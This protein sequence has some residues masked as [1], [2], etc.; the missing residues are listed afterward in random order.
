M[1]CVPPH[2]Q[3]Q[4]RFANPAGIVWE[5]VTVSAARSLIIET[6]LISAHSWFPG[7]AWAIVSCAGCRTH[8]GW[9]YVPLGGG[10]GFWGLIGSRLLEDGAP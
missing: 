3:P 6:A 7:H 9:R 4:L 5:I 2:R 10:A 8:L 1:I